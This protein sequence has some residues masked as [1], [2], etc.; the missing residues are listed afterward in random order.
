V[1][2]R[3]RV[4]GWEVVVAGAV[5]SARTRAFVWGTHDCATWAFDLRR[6]LTG[7]D[8]TATRWRG[9]YKTARGSLRVMRRL[10]W[11]SMQDMGVALLGEPLSNVRLA[12]RG[13]LVLSQD[14]TAFGV[15]LGAQAA[16]LAL[17]GVTLRT[18]KSCAMAW[19]T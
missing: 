7:G 19:R 11:D 15:C 6:D 1:G 8:N 18:L 12:Q 10:G 17:E 5:E 16:F 14:A 9:A 3:M 2:S 13:D 4:A